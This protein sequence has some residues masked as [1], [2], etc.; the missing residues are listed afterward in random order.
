MGKKCADLSKALVCPSY[1]EDIPAPSSGITEIVLSVSTHY[2]SAA[3][4][5]ILPQTGLLYRPKSAFGAL[6]AGGDISCR[7]VHP[8]RT[9]TFHVVWHFFHLPILAFLSL[10]FSALETKTRLELEKHCGFYKNLQERNERKEK[11]PFTT[12]SLLI[13]KWWFGNDDPTYQH[14]NPVCE[15]A[16]PAVVTKQQRP[17]WLLTIKHLYIGFLCLWTWTVISLH[18][19]FPLDE[20]T[21]YIMAWWKLHLTIKHPHLIT[22]KWLTTW[23]SQVV[24]Q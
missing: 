14:Y 16:T 1:T 12:I 24:G 5:C 15:W 17:T 19:V 4:G 10:L 2:F 8:I 6:K 23:Y 9:F 13:N 20:G 11:N 7:F 21:W 3:N 18:P 22:K